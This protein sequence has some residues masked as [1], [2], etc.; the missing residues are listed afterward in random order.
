M[1]IQLAL[2]RLLAILVI[3]AFFFIGGK[4]V[5]FDFYSPFL[6]AHYLMAVIFLAN[7]KKVTSRGNRY[8]A[9]LVLLAITAAVI[10]NLQFIHILVY[11]GI[12][13]ILTDIYMPRYLG[14][15]QTVGEII[16][17]VPF[18]ALSY[19]FFIRELP[20]VKDILPAETHFYLT[21][22][23]FI[24]MTFY[25]IWKKKEFPWYEIPFLIAVMASFYFEFVFEPYSVIFYHIILWLFLPILKLRWKASKMVGLHFLLYGIFVAFPFP[26]NFLINP[27]NC[28]GDH[29]IGFIAYFHITVSF[30]TSGLNPIFLQRAL[31]FIK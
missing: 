5:A 2:A 12:H 3:S 11:F 27:Q 31:G 16:A 19:F 24:I 20:I 17:R 9:S 23:S 18:T 15:K 10:T 21:G 6:M 4:Q 25:F 14:M 22:M 13:S 7:I 30:G 8:I 26:D 29:C 28:W 1:A